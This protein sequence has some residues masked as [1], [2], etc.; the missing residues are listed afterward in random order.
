[1]S[2]A[3]VPP[4]PPGWITNE[5]DG[6]T[7][8]PPKPLRFVMYTQGN[9]LLRK[10]EYYN[11]VAVE[12]QPDLRPEIYEVHAPYTMVMQRGVKKVLKR[13]KRK[14]EDTSVEDFVRMER[15]LTMMNN[16]DLAIQAVELERRGI[17]KLFNRLW[18][19]E[20]HP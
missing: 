20:K 2:W 15:V 9:A 14:G 6:R 18:E 19:E 10:Y 8:A 16:M 4:S 7:V 11:C 3:P 13:T 5:P 12:L 17:Q 1:M